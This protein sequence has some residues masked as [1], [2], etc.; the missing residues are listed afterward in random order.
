MIDNDNR[1]ISDCVRDLDPGEGFE[2]ML[3]IMNLD[4]SEMFELNPPRGSTWRPQMT[5]SG[6]IVYVCTQQDNRPGARFCS[7]REDGSGFRVL[8]QQHEANQ[9]DLSN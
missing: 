7:I 9:F 6:T 3:C 1:L 8:L 2:E 5:K 4:G